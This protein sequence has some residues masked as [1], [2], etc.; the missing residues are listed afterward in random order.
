MQSRRQQQQQQQQLQNLGLATR[1]IHAGQQPEENN[2]QAVV[3]P[4]VTS[5]TYKQNEPGAQRV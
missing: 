5:V 2:C 1:A 4:I 3:T